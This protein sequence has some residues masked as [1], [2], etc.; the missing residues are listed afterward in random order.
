MTIDRERV[1]EVIAAGLAAAELEIET[2]RPDTW[3]VVL[4]GEW[5]RTLPVMLR[6]DER[7]LHV[8][9][10]LCGAPDEGHEDVYRLLLQR[11]QRALPIHFALDDQGDVLMT[12]HVA[13][14]ALDEAVLDG[15]LGSL[16]QTADEVFNG[17]LRRGFAT[18]LD[19]EQRWRA[20]H[21]LPPNPVGTPAPGS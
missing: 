2:P 7:S 19:A 13:L 9:A 12:G 18:Y 17:I 1:R 14:A 5:K 15:V 3:L 11:N 8:T 16:V 21:G 10:L 4:S 20:A 6:L